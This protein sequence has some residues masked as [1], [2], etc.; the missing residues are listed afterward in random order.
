LPFFKVAKARAFIVYTY[1]RDAL[2]QNQSKRALDESHKGGYFLRKKPLEGIAPG[3]SFSGFA[4]VT[5]C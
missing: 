4:I 1:Q 5:V 3:Y 2:E